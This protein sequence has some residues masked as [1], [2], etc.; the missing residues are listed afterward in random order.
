MYKPFCFSGTNQVSYYQ[1]KTSIANL[2][3]SGSTS[4]QFYNCIFPKMRMYDMS[5]S[6]EY[7]FL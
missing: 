7:I 1:L 6:L 5:V 3:R 2:F 4:R